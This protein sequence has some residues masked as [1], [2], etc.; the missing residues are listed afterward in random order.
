MNCK[1]RECGLDEKKE[2][3]KEK[4]GGAVGDAG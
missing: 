4:K 1:F 2:I 3:E